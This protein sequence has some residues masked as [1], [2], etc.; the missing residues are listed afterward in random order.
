MY[1]ESCYLVVPCLFA[2]YFRKLWMPGICHYRTSCNCALNQIFPS[3]ISRTLSDCSYL[4]DSYLISNDVAFYKMS[5]NKYQTLKLMLTRCGCLKA[6]RIMAFTSENAWF[7]RRRENKIVI[8]RKMD[9]LNWVK[10]G[11]GKEMG[12]L[13]IRCWEGQARWSNGHENE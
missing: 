13:R 2:V 10:E 1:S 3:L 6:L 7:S 9:A 12:R 4:T 5:V 8:K 11:M